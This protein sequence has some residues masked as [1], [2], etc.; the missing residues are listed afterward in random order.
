MLDWIFFLNKSLPHEYRDTDQ[1]EINIF[2]LC[3]FFFAYIDGGVFLDSRYTNRQRFN[4]F[5]HIVG[6]LLRTVRMRF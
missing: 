5:V 4:N 2:A 1:Y 3:I 6:L